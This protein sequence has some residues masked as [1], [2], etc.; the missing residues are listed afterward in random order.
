ML[1]DVV[2]PAAGTG[3][4]FNSALPK[5]YATIGEKTVLACSVDIFLKNAF[6]N[7]IVVVHAPSDPYIHQLPLSN[8]VRLTA[9]GQTRADSVL[10]GLQYL[11]TLDNPSQW[12]MV[13]DAA[14][15]CFEQADLTHLCEKV[16]EM[17]AA[18]IVATPVSSTI[19]QV[20][21]M[22]IVSSLDRT[23][24]WAAQTPQVAPSA[25][26]IEALS[27][28]ITSPLPVTDEASALELNGVPVHI[29]QGKTTNIKIT[30]AEDLL[31]AR[32]ILNV[33]S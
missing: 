6:I 7:N 16:K 13:H 23:M 27:F 17:K 8:R 4:R 1:F 11:Q 33:R 15:P 9:G 19:K 24:L 20:S 29:V 25:V 28:A 12:V 10:A 5:Q 3:Q 2:I 21:D 30:T 22:R 18:V 31:L 14:R 32:S 26:L